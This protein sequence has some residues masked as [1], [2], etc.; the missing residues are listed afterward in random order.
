MTD[1]TCRLILGVL[2]LTF[3]YF[4]FNRGIRALIVMLVFE[5]VTN[6]QVPRMVNAMCSLGG[7]G[8]CDQDLA[9]LRATSRLRFDSQRGFRPLAPMML[10]LNYVLFRENLWLPT[11]FP[12]F[13]I[14]GAGVGSVCPALTMMKRAGFS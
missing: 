13:S 12:G 7:R 6:L 9:P 3:L 11:W 5:G 2:L 4:D 14:L 10:V 8:T 1:R